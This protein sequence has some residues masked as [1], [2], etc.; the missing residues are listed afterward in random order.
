ML[1][2]DEKI[3][4]FL[5]EGLRPET[6]PMITMFRLAQRRKKYKRYS[7]YFTKTY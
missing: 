3:S 4:G 6:F 5:P 2:S 7:K 1:A